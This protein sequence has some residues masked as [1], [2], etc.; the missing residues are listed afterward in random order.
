MRVA[1]FTITSMTVSCD[2]HRWSLSGYLIACGRIPDAGLQSGGRCRTPIVA[3]GCN[4]KAGVIEAVIDNRIEKRG[5][6]R[7]C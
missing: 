1:K 2:D 3:T 7:R 4:A 6:E 5:S